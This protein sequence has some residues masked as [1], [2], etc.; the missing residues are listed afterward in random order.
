MNKLQNTEQVHSVMTASGVLYITTPN[1]PTCD[2]QRQHIKDY[3]KS[4]TADLIGMSEFEITDNTMYPANQLNIKTA[5]SFAFIKNGE[6]MGVLNGFYKASVLD[7]LCKLTN[8]GTKEQVAAQLKQLNGTTLPDV[9][10]IEV[11][12]EEVSPK[13]TREAIQNKIEDL[14]NK[15]HIATGDKY[16]DSSMNDEY[17]E[18]Y[19]K[20]LVEPLI[21]W[22]LTKN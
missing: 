10:N 4:G 12:A 18:A 7:N 19:D 2:S 8:S 21:D 11:Q 17:N 22:I 13:L 3:I 9:K 15:F 16:V 6:C 5:P 20:H 14:G 1:C